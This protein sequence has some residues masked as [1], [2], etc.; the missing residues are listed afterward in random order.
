M[1]RFL[2]GW[3]L[4]LRTLWRLLKLWCRTFELVY[5]AATGKKEPGRPVDCFNIP[6]IRPRPDPYIYSQYWLHLRGIAYTWD[7]PDFKIIDPI[8]GVAVDNHHLQPNK[9]YS[10]RATIHNGSIMGAVH[11]TVAFEVLHFGAGTVTA[12]VLGSVIVDVPAFGSTVAEIDWT[13]PAT[14]GHN[15]LR[16]IISH[17]DD[18]NPLNNVGQHNT[19]VAAPASPTRKL[20]FYVGN[21]SERER[22]F[23]LSM[24]SY[25]LPAQPLRPGSA[26]GAAAAGAGP[27]RNSLAYLQRLREI[28]DFRKFPVPAFLNATLAHP[29][30]RLQ[31]G[32]EF[33]TFIEMLPPKVGQGRQC[34][35]VNVTLG[36]MLVGGVTAYVEEA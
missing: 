18:A 33:E 25:R 14:A 22:T 9:K 13:T 24:N 26:R 31:P 7:N 23:A 32:E 21:Q 35:N 19:D 17:P 34:I 1:R 30:L 36:E 16:A 28:N 10:V 8:N 15:C 5:E 6:N 27:A 2:D 11:T 20:K 4:I 3:I 29:E 12:Q